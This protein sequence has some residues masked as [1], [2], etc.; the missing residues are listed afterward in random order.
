MKK[1]I[2]NTAVILSL[3]VITTK[4]MAQQWGD[5]TLYSTQNGTAA[6]LV[7][8]LGN[9]FHTW[10]FSNT[11]KTGYSS[12]MLPGGYLLRSVAH[13]G[14]QL[15][16]GGMTGEVQKVDWSGTVVWDYVYSSSTYCLHHDICPL[17]NGNVLMISYDVKTSAQVTQAGSSVS[18]NSFW[19]DK[20]I[21]VQPTGATT[22]S[23]VWEWHAWDHL[24]QNY[25]NT[26]DNYVTNIVDHPEL[27]NIN[28]GNT[29]QTTDWLHMNGLDYNE[30]LDEIIVSSHFMNEFY[31][32]DHSTT[33]AEAA[34]HSGGN[35]THGGDI[36]YRWGNPAAYS[37]SGTTNFN[38]I[39]DAHWVPANCPHAN[40]M[41]GYNNNGQGTANSYVDY[42]NP[43]YNG[44]NYTH[45]AGQAY[46]PIVRDKRIVVNGQNS[47]MGNSQQ[48]PNGNVLI[49]VAQSGYIYEIDSNANILWSKTV[50]GFVPQAFRYTG[51]YI[52]GSQPDAPTITQA[53]N[54][55]T[56]GSTG[57]SY[58]WYKDGVAI[59][60]AT[61]QSYTATSTGTYTV[62]IKDQYGCG[63]NASNGIYFNNDGVI[64]IQ[65][66]TWKL[67]PNPS[68][69]LVF[70]SN[71][72][73]IHD[74]YHVNVFDVTGKLLMTETDAQVV[75]LS[76]LSNGC[77][78][79]NI[80]QNGVDVY[81]T[82]VILNK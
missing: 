78:L 58:Q 25:N 9:N 48:L 60:G 53:G 37:A 66:G 68:S 82:K 14:N 35:S 72:G 15:N 28:Y 74:D 62:V 46:A 27:L 4:S 47:N 59:S 11:Y 39:H 8:T 33:T 73:L 50:S 77:Y 75:D 40:W 23:I 32:I 76:A 38:T 7:D 12:Y 51:C 2:F 19:P 42:V 64:E 24:M 17:P 63:S 16:G 20:I 49:C 29:T 52:S 41:V 44:Y 67:L 79:I 5:Y 65:S 34:S 61:S 70:I 26:K 36:L 31:V 6:Y 10:T 80:N 3:F 71:S 13:T 1:I 69:G 55:L 56:C 54:V 57:T 45:V 18:H 43:P 21:E 22:G 30:A 81:H